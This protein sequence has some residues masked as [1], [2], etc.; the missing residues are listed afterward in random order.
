MRSLSCLI[1]ILFSAALGAQDLERVEINYD[2]GKVVVRTTDSADDFEKLKEA[3][4]EAAR[5]KLLYRGQPLRIVGL[6]VDEQFQGIRFEYD[7]A[8]FVLPPKGSLQAG[9]LGLLFVAPS[10]KTALARNQDFAAV[11]AEKKPVELVSAA[12]DADVNLS[13]GLQAAVD[14]KPLYFW[15]AKANY[16]FLLLN[17]WGNL[18]PSF[19]G[20]ASKQTNADPDSL[21]A[22]LR[23]KNRWPV[24]GRKG[25]IL[26]GDIPA[27]EFESSV[28]DE[29]LVVNGALVQRK[30]LK[31]NANVTAGGELRW[32]HGARSVN[33]QLGAGAD[34]GKATSRTIKTDSNGQERTSVFR[35]K[36]LVKMTRIWQDESGKKPVEL[37]GSYTLR[38][39]LQPEP[40]QK[41]DVNAGKPTLSRVPRHW[42]A[43]DLGVTLT[44]GI[45][46]TGQYRY[47]ALPP[48][49]QFINH[50][51][52]VGFSFLMRL[53]KRFKVSSL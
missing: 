52:T 9:E 11:E 37:E 21:K 45:K 18:G 51:V 5:W 17:G 15:E 33:Y 46:L 20:S 10:G 28:K 32:V 6:S 29:S 14:A 35:P 2:T 7:P 1:A 48:S 53:P 34:V 42:V 39:P 12:K 8:D 50:R 19:E 25:L 36:A 13:G 3:Y 26:E 27:Y 44:P 47:G 43:V 4:G 23:Y 30:F 16:P 31:K 49:F 41:L 40:F 22:K 24:G 38:W